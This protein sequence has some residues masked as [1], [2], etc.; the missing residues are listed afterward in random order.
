MQAVLAQTVL[1]LVSMEWLLSCKTAERVLTLQ[2]RAVPLIAAL[3][4]PNVRGVMY[5]GPLLGFRSTNGMSSL[6]RRPLLLLLL[7]NPLPAPITPPKPQCLDWPCPWACPWPWL[8]PPVAFD[9][10]K[11]STVFCS[12]WL[13]LVDGWGS[14]PRD[15][16]PAPHN[17]LFLRGCCVAA[18]T[19]VLVWLLLVLVLVADAGVAVDVAAPACVVVGEVVVGAV[20][21]VR[22]WFCDSSP[23][24]VTTAPTGR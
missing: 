9:T 10:P 6:T 24:H 8:K 23:T 14:E 7:P 15:T 20:V 1:A 3:S 11:P 12:P 13:V 2:F 19:P 18:V 21:V 4:W 17:Q 5:D 16:S 22:M